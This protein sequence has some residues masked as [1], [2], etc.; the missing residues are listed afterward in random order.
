MR[1]SCV[2]LVLAFL[3][4]GCSDPKRTTPAA[5]SNTTGGAP[6]GATPDKG[7]GMNSN[8]EAEGA[9]IAKETIS[10]FD[11]AVA[12]FASALADKPDEAIAMPKLEA[13]FAAYRP[14]MEALAARRKALTDPEAKGGFSRHMDTNRGQAVFR[15]DQ[16]LGIYVAHYRMMKPGPKIVEFLTSKVVGLIDI[17]HGS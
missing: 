1:A 13:I 5:D 16:A 6:E 2:W 12:E 3:V 9:A 17:V 7:A 8:L 4:F 14:K 11:N 10:E 15:S